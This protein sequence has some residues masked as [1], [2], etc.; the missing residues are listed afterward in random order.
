[1]NEQTSGTVTI[2]QPLESL[3]ESANDENFFDD[4]FADE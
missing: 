1:M 2:P 3:V 4:F